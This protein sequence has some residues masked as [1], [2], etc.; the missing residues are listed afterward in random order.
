MNIFEKKI[1]KLL[2]L[3]KRERGSDLTY[4][5]QEPEGPLDTPADKLLIIEKAIR[6]FS[7]EPRNSQT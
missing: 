7:L 2:K 3:A 4:S 1:I 5:L 6:P